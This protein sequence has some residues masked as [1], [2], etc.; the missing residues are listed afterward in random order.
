MVGKKSQKSHVSFLR[1]DK[2]KPENQLPYFYNET[3]KFTELWLL[4]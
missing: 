2:H 1:E 4:P 3:S